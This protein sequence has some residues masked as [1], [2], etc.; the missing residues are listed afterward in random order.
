VRIGNADATACNETNLTVFFACP[1]PTLGTFGP[2][3][4]LRTGLNIPAG[5]TPFTLTDVGGNPIVIPCVIATAPGTTMVQALAFATNNPGGCQR[6]P[7][8][9]ANAFGTTSLTVTHPC[10]QITKQCLTAVNI[11][12]AVVIT[13][14]GTV[15]NC[16]DT[17][18]QNVNVVNNQPAPNT[19][20]LQIAGL[21]PGASTNFTRSYTNTSNICGPFTDILTVTGQDAQ[22]QV[23][24]CPSSLV[25]N[26]SAPATCN[27]VY[28]PCINVTK[29]C[30]TNLLILCN[31]NPTTINFSGVV[32]NCGNITLTNVTLVDDLIGPGI[33][34]SIPSLAPGQSA[35][36]STNL[37]ITAALCGRSNIVN[38]ITARGTNICNLTRRSGWE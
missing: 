38:T 13:Y 23:T 21:A 11:G 22:N 36:W 32:S 15:T 35:P 1:G 33:I 12:N 18:L 6:G 19:P 34:A 16:G 10:V 30:S 26:S 28:T 17:P 24:N 3:N 37:P 5:T 8:D 27:I 4:I 29:I 9:T 20:V 14:S 7:Q 25:T 2:T 31:S